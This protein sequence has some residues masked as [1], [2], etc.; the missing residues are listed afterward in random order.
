MIVSSKNNRFYHKNASSH[1]PFSDDTLFS[2]LQEPLVALDDIPVIQPSPQSLSSFSKDNT[3]A[4]I[5]FDQ[6]FDDPNMEPLPFA[7][8]PSVPD[9]HHDI[10]TENTATRLWTHKS[11][12]DATHDDY[13]SA[14]PPLIGQEQFESV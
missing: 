2:S 6:P 8:I 11:S 4:A 10:V 9:V 12:A 1:F 14:S 5:A 13:S 3:I 7:T